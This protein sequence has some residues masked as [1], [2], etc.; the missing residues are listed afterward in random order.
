[1]VPVRLRERRRAAEA[2]DAGGEQPVDTAEDVDDDGVADGSSHDEDMPS[3]L[4]DHA[5]AAR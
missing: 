3:R 1:V 2:P 5:A 4:G